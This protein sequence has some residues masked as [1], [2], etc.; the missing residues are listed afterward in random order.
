MF[1]GNI[2]NFGDF[3]ACRN[4]KYVPMEAEIGVIRGKYCLVS[5]IGSSDHKWSINEPFDWREV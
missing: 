4:F 3:D 5:Y 1:S 2:F